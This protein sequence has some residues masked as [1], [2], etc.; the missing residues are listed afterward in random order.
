MHIFAVA[1]KIIMKALQ[2]A[3]PFQQSLTMAES[4]CAPP[5]RMV[6]NPAKGVAE[7]NF[8]VCTEPRREAIF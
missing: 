6:S 7:R 5:L 4:I 1:V 2:S 3:L 8:N